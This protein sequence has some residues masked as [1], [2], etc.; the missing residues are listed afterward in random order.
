M[1]AL[2]NKVLYRK[3]RK[4]FLSLTYRTFI[5][6][7]TFH[8]SSNQQLWHLAIK[9]PKTSSI[10]IDKSNHRTL[11]KQIIRLT[12]NPLYRYFRNRHHPINFAFQ[13]YRVGS[14]ATSNS[15]PP[16]TAGSVVKL[17]PKSTLDLRCRSSPAGEAGQLARR[18]SNSNLPCSIG[19]SS[20]LPGVTFRRQ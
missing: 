1:R 17:P 8:V 15:F 4:P 3:M 10:Q 19:R 13:G 12:Y 20:F 5:H 6:L 16:L 11:Y 14:N 9:H 2:H 18:S 7:L